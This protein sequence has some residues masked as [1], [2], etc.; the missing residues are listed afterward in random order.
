MENLAI[1][2]EVNIDIIDNILDRIREENSFEI[3]EKLLK[4]LLSK[5]S[6]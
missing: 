2:I 6:T 3:L 1:T 5:A 4:F